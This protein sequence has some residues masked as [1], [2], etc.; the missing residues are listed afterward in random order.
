VYPSIPCA[1]ALLALLLLGLLG[2]AMARRR[3]GAALA[4]LRRAAVPPSRG[5]ARR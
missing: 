2:R 3:T 1:A 4:P 5:I